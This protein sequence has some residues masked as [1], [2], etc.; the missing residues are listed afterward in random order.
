MSVDT[1]LTDALTEATTDAPT[2]VIAPPVTMPEFCGTRQGTEVC[3]RIKDHP[4]G[5]SWQSD[6]VLNIMAMQIA[7]LHR[8]VT[9]IISQMPPGMIPGL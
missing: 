2:T 9:G 4:G 1:A 5:C 7:E 6:I 3:D 8:I